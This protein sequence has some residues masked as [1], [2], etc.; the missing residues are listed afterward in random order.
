MTDRPML[1]AVPKTPKESF[2]PDR[3]ASHLLRS[4][5]LHLQEALTKHVAEICA[6]L[7]TNPHKLVSEKEFS[8]YV[9]KVTAVLHPQGIRRPVK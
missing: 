1:I 6:L 7:K 3:A 4:Q 8:E 2:N 5:A 9:Q